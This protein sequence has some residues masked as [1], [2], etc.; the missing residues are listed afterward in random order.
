V[1][2]FISTVSSV[3]RSTTGGRIARRRAILVTII[4]CDVVVVGP[5][6]VA[7]SCTLRIL[8]V[9]SFRCVRSALNRLPRRGRATNATWWETNLEVVHNSGYFLLVV[10]IVN[11]S[12]AEYTPHAFEHGRGEMKAFIQTFVR[13]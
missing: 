11:Q 7:L 10:D 4:G 12:L 2:L 5:V 13:A 6:V 3:C 9:I 8:L 1:R